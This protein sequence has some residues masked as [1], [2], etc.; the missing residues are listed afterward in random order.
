M[1]IPVSCSDAPAVLDTA[2]AVKVTNYFGRSRLD[3]IY[4]YMRI[5]VSGGELVFSL[6][7]FEKSPPPDSRIAAVFCF[8]ERETA[9]LLYISTNP[10]PDA[11][12][13]ILSAD[14]S[15]HAA[16]LP[17][18]ERFGGSDEE[19]YYWGC[20]FRLGR[21]FLREQFGVLIVPGTVFLG[22]VFKFADGEDAFGEAFGGGN[23]F[24]SR[25]DLGEFEA[26]GF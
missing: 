10:E 26:V 11:E 15:R 3:D 4:A 1:R 22:N 9:P 17:N 25:A 13:L 20:S 21:D 7:S 8:G 12:C 16:A 23:G 6:T 18:P 5:C 24:P 14:G 2:G 19:G